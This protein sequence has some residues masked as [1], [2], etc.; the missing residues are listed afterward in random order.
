MSWPLLTSLWKTWMIR[1][2]ATLTIVV[3][4]TTMNEPRTITT[5]ACQ[6]Y[7]ISVR[8]SRKRWRGLTP[9]GC[10]TVAIPLPGQPACD[11][12]GSADLT[13]YPEIGVA[14][15]RISSAHLIR[16]RSFAPLRVAQ[17]D[18][19]DSAGHRQCLRAG[20]SGHHGCHGSGYSV[21]GSRAW[22]RTSAEVP[23]GSTTPRAS[24]AIL[25]GTYWVTL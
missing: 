22:I 21:A 1:G 16:P 14:C 5:S 25:T 23:S 24:T 17:D 10:A 20:S 18:I 12:G 6:W 7:G 2:S 4:R 11:H 9:S 8:R 3:S 13:C 15:R 19:P